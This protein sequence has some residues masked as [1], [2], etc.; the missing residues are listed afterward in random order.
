MV[1]SVNAEVDYNNPDYNGDDEKGHRNAKDGER[2]TSGTINAK[3]TVMA[4]P[5][6]K[7]AVASKN[8]GNN[9]HST[10]TK[11]IYSGNKNKRRQPDDVWDLES[12][13]LYLSTRNITS[14]NSKEGPFENDKEKNTDNDKAKSKRDNK[15]DDDYD[16]RE[17]LTKD[18][19]S[20]ITFRVA[21]AGD[22]API[23]HWYRRQRLEERRRC[24]RYYLSEG[25]RQRQLISSTNNNEEEENDAAVDDEE[26]PEID[27]HQQDHIN[28]AIID[29][30][31]YLTDNQHPREISNDNNSS[32]SNLEDEETSSLKLE[33][34]LAEGLGDE[35]KCPSVYGLL[36][37]VHRSPLS[38]S[39]GLNTIDTKKNK[40]EK[41]EENS[42]NIK[43]NTKKKS[44]PEN[45]SGS[46]AA[47]VLLSLAW[48][49]SG[50]RNLRIEWMVVDSQLSPSPSVDVDDD[51]E[52]NSKTRLEASSVEQKVW[53]RINTLSIM[54]ACQE[55]SVDEDVLMMTS[56]STT[57]FGGP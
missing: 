22:A 51:N 47:V 54:T 41:D 1:N 52:N 12:A 21:H 55:I 15:Y 36:A 45:L 40:D 20:W 27:K 46:L 16:Q 4:S 48:M 23:A 43:K 28:H 35:N 14:N 26:E 38:S 29:E 49:D 5:M 32:S 30:E 39:L 6:M 44:L 3:D 37:Y 34:W 10:T 9:K 57:T 2:E 18:K 53:L 8:G 17:Y 13:L 50:K 33:H 25:R 56:L 42:K 31:K 11:I 19:E 24:R 7:M